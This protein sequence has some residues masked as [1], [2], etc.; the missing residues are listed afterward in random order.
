[1]S[2]LSFRD[3]DAAVEVAAAENKDVM[4]KIWARHLSE[5]QEGLLKDFLRET[6]QHSGFSE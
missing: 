4:K 5:E 2:K 1:M 6:S 3:P